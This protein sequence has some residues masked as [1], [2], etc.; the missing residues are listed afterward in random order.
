MADELMTMAEAAELLRVSYPTIIR[1]T[2]PGKNGEAPR[3]RARKLGHRTVRVLRSDVMAMLDAAPQPGPQ[4]AE[5]T[6]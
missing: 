5:P 6:T 1:M 2:R 4:P 3:L